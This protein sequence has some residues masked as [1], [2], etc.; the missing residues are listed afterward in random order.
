[1]IGKIFLTIMISISFYYS[2]SAHLSN[3]EKRNILIS[4]IVRFEDINISN[5]GKY[6]ELSFSYTHNDKE[7]CNIIYRYHLYDQIYPNFYDWRPD[8]YIECPLLQ[9]NP[10]FNYDM[11]SMCHHQIRNIGKIVGVNKTNQHYFEVRDCS[12]LTLYFRSFVMGYF[13]EKYPKVDITGEKVNKFITSSIAI[14]KMSISIDDILYYNSADTLPFL[15]ITMLLLTCSTV[16]WIIFLVG[17]L[18]LL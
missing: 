5:Y 14:Y 15:S 2:Y 11:V 8:I 10:I 12:N 7:N 9:A 18:S 3:I 4:E 1:M 6:D 13:E 16:Y 17:K